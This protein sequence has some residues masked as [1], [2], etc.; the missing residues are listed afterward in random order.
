MNG[1][2]YSVLIA[3]D[4][5][6]TREKLRSIIS[7]EEYG[8]NFLEPAVDGEDAL[9]KVEKYK[10]DILIT[11]INMPFL[12]GVE[13]LEKIYEKY[14]DIIT[15][16]ISGYDD[17]EYVKSTFMSG[18][19]NYLIKPVT[20]IDM[21]RAINLALRKI[22]E[23]EKDKIEVLKMASVLQDKE[24]SQMIQ[25]R[26][27]FFAPSFS[28]NDYV[29]LAGMSLMIVK[30]HN[31]QDVVQAGRHD[32]NLFSYQ[33]KKKIRE[34]FKDENL[35][36]FNNVY[37]MNEFIAVSDK[38]EE[39]I[40]GISEKLR[41]RLSSEFK[42][43]LTICTSRHSY[44]VDNIYMAYVE[45]VSLLMM[46]RYCASDEIVLPVKADISEKDVKV[47]FDLKCENQLKA[48][49]SSGKPEKVRRVIFKEIGIQNSIADG[50]SFLEMKQ[51]IR[52]IM[53][54]IS[55][56]VLSK[57]NYAK[58]GELE[59][60]TDALDKV[61][62]TLDFSALQASLDEVTGFLEPEE[63]EVVPDSIR[64][65]VRQAVKWIDEHYSEDISLA[66]LAKKY[67][68]ESSYFSKMFRQETGET[69]I[70]YITN[71]RVK[72]AQEYMEWEERP[73]SEVAFLV[74]YDDYTYFSRVFKKSTGFSPR[75]YRSRKKEGK[76]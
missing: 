65:I 54:I 74:G 19:I 24:Y 25:P 34:L 41:I 56:Y 60:Y 55:E 1:K 31:F 51:T 16:V 23:K 62:E 22:S 68:V 36:V 12:N 63:K 49:L 52:Q 66:G 72:K 43:L 9:E 17:F 7:W 47:R 20:K 18:A 59:S 21:I 75:E 69:L 73:M 70:I 3:D 37:R 8:L 14:S 26:E 40:G 11:D 45:A 5:Y 35:I 30:I 48:A 15:F 29:E 46:R 61:I 71:K 67:H 76:V 28:I 50:W 44:S 38:I 42:C 6:W 58:A 64:D 57:K 2:K 32:M 27:T 33:I 39:E 13:L 4:E 10:P 53:N